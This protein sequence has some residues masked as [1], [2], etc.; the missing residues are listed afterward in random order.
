METSERNPPAIATLLA[1]LRRRIRLYVW[2]QGLSATVLLLAAGF[3]ASLGLDLAFEPP[4]ALRGA[5]LLMAAVAVAW[6]VYRSILRRAFVELAD[7]HMALLL[8]RRYP[9]FQDSLITTV[10]LASPERQTGFSADMLATTRQSALATVPHVRVGEV[11]NSRPLARRLA[12]S[13]LLAASVIAFGLVATEAFGVWARRSLLL[14]EELW[15]RKTH[16]NAEGFGEDHRIKVALGSDFDLVVTADAAVGRT[17]PDTVE[18]QLLDGTGRREPMSREGEAVPGLD[19]YQKYT[20]TFKAVLSSVDFY[21]LGGDDRRGPFHIEAVESPT[22]NQMV[23]HCQYPAYMNRT[24]RDLAVAGVVQLPQGTQ[25][26][27]EGQSN[28]D[29]VRV[30][31]DEPV[32]K[33]TPITRTLNLARAHA[34]G[35]APRNFRFEIPRL[36]ADKALLF[37]L[38]D[39]DAIRSREPIRLSLAVVAD[40]APQVAVQLAGIGRAVTPQARLPAAG[41]ITDDYGVAK[42]WFEYHVD[43]RAAQQRPIAI[44]AKRPSEVTISEVLP[45]AELVLEPKQKLHVAVHAQD[46]FDLTAAPN[47]GVSQKYVLDVVTPEQLLALLEARELTL[48]R[49]FETIIE[50]LTDTRNL[51]ARIEF[52][53]A[54]PTTPPAPSVP[55]RTAADPTV[56]PTAEPVVEPV[57]ETDQAPVTEPAE[58]TA[59]GPSSSRPAA[60]PQDLLD[61]RRTQVERAIQNIQRS[62]QET[63]DLAGAFAAIHD[64]LVNNQI[65]NQEL[66]E[67]LQQ[68]I[69]D[70]LTKIA[71]QSDPELQTRLRKLQAA[72]GDASAGRNAQADAVVQADA[73]LVEMQLV[74]GKMLQLETF[75]EIVD[76][77]RGIIDSQDK[78]S[79]QTKELQTQTLRNL[80][81]KE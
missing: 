80:R 81:E 7:R 9:H 27:I 41:T 13:G 30:Q 17:I 74:L 40:E 65:D 67:R 35:D 59:P 15:P 75:T 10:E 19:P 73:I 47:V 18:V 21:V 53:E 77:L 37:T 36:D 52:G 44:D 3:W 39:S 25:V 29:L 28:K 63:L 14:S 38:W 57:A 60:S 56:E 20:H 45:A 68:G 5:F 1:D 64:E 54:Q 32:E 51:I 78:V 24:P 72:L 43:D 4:P 61:R 12:I 76:L 62:T 26:T 46:T 33:G 22:I 2:S 71:M 16:L 31:I 23:L 69:A 79:Q 70:P 55:S 49:R 6:L 58:G 34:S 66:K 8:E 48:R 42:A 50:E 11:L